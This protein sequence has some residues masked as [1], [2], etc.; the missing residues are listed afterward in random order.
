MRI[1]NIGA[2]LLVQ[3]LQRFGQDV[4]TVGT[5]QKLSLTTDHP[6]YVARLLAKVQSL[7]FQPDVLFYCDQ[8]NLPLL[9]DPEN[10]PIPSIW[11]SID[12]YCNPWHIPYAHG[13]D[14]T[15]V[16]Q[17]DFVPLFTQEGL[18]AFWFPLFCQTSLVPAPGQGLERDVPV[19]FV[20]NI[21]HKNNPQRGPFL[22]AFRA[23]APLV[24]HCGA[25]VPLFSR[26]K[27]VLNQTAFSEVNFRCFEA[28]ACGA[29]LLM[30]RCGN[31][32]LELI[33]HDE[34][35]PTYTRND[36][37]QAAAIANQA[38]SDPA[39]LADIAKAGQNAVLSRHTDRHRAQSLIKHF[40]NLDH[41]TRPMPSE[42]RKAASP[43]VRAA[44]GILSSELTC[45]EM[46]SYQHFFAEIAQGHRPKKSEQPS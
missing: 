38:L 36:A 17:K 3:A 19:A 13:F 43:F 26:A 32:L 39:R 2:P 37:R 45:A 46:R 5:D 7:G 11:Y 10:L 30:E 42:R 29:A 34:M 22:Q 4:F 44:F 27:I 23:L 1:L 14:A 25:F 41:D 21:G 31:G 40:Q 20:G 12:T 35:L 15:L 28:M 16:A 18:R 8:G 33:G 6:F 9:L 24:I